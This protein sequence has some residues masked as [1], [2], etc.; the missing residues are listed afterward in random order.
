MSH[1]FETGFKVRTASWHGLE[2]VV[3]EY[4][5]DGEE[6]LVLSG[7]STWE[8]LVE[9]SYF[10]KYPENMTVE[11]VV[12]C[13][14]P[15]G[16]IVVED[17]RG[18]KVLR[19]DNQ[20]VLAS[21]VGAGWTP[22]FNRTLVDVCEALVDAGDGKLLYETMGSLDEGRKVYATVML[23]EPWVI[24]D[25]DTMITYP[26]M[27]VTNAHDGAGSFYAMPS[28][29]EVV[30][31]N[32]AKLAEIN[33]ERSGR[34]F[35]FNHTGNVMDRIEEAKQALAGLRD[36]AAKIREAE[37]AL[38]ALPINDDQAH[39]FAQLFAATAVPSEAGISERVKAN[40]MRSQQAFI[41]LYSESPTIDGHRGTALGVFRAATEYLDHV[42]GYRS[43]ST[44][45][46]RSLLAI[47]PLKTQAYA[48]AQQVA[49]AA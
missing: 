29:F 3:A 26:F 34:Q 44:Y 38:F 6:A 7:L 15:D 2:D 47:E 11:D 39:T 48:L 30:C 25:D 20:K 18:R 17:V 24:G 37:E 46:Y 41:T 49:V 35:K 28:T 5:K 32:T 21:S 16:R 40:A 45:A 42:R 31:A 14:L 12:L 10:I 36:E 1:L 9:P 22:V 19:S 8:P 27:A 23:D 13:T 33:G 43:K 4:P